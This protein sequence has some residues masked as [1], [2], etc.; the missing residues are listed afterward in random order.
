MHRKAI[1]K[2]RIAEIAKA[3]R[4]FTSMKNRGQQKCLDNALN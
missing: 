3:S 1:W 4:G 2:L